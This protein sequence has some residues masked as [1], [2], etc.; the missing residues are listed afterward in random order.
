[1]V[2][3]IPHKMLRTLAKADRYLRAA[4][5]LSPEIPLPGN[6]LSEGGHDWVGRAGKKSVTAEIPGRVVSGISH[7]RRRVWKSNTI[8]MQ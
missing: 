3:M 5:E 6:G 2:P 4:G 7:R 8:W 1:M